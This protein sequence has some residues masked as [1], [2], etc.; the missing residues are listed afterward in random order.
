M[1]NPFITFFTMIFSYILAFFAVYLVW[2]DTL[3]T[4]EA[5]SLSLGVFSVSSVMGDVLLKSIATILILAVPPS[6]QMYRNYAEFFPQS[7]EFNLF[8]DY[9]GIL[10]SIED[11]FSI[12]DRATLRIAENW[13]EVRREHLA[14]FNQQLQGHEGLQ[15]STIVSSTTREGE[16]HY[17]FHKASRFHQTYQMDSGHGFVKI[18][19]DQEL[20]GQQITIHYSLRR[21]DHDCIK[22]SFK[23]LFVTFTKVIHPTFSQ[24]VHIGPRDRLPIV[25]FVSF[26][27]LRFFPWSD[28][29]NTLYCV[30]IYPKSTDDHPPE[31]VPIA[32]AVYDLR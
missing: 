8:F 28:I 32:Y 18:W 4:V 9:Q 31:F 6:I 2:T 24:Y 19:F 15:L 5:L 16:F 21:T 12:E 20:T 1:K 7:L 25:N 17:K 14:I 26:T 10:Q 30:E 3:V 29:G 27:K 13:K 23:D 11:G 22:A